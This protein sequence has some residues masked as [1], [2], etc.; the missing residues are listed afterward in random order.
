MILQRL[1]RPPHLVDSVYHYPYCR[2]LPFSQQTRRVETILELETSFQAQQYVLR[3]SK[4]E[5]KQGSERPFSYQNR[6]ICLSRLFPASTPLNSVSTSTATERNEISLIKPSI[7]LQTRNR[8][9]RHGSIPRQQNTSSFQRLPLQIRSKSTNVASGPTLLKEPLSP[10]PSYI[11]P[12]TGILSYLPSSF[13]PYAELIRLDKPT[14][15]YYLFFPCLFSTLLAASLTPITPPS[16]VISTTFLFFAGALV[17]RGAGC[18]IN[19]L[20]DRKLDAHVSRTRFRPLARG[21]LTPFSALAFTSTQLLLGLGVLLQ[22]PLPCLAYGIPSLLLVATYPLFKRI[23]H[24]PQL[25]L[26]LTF[27]WGA[28]MGFP[29]LGI[30]LVTDSTAQAAAACLYASCISWTVLYDFIYA[31]MDLKDDVTAGIKSIAVKHG[32]QTKVILASL[33][34]VQVGLLATAGMVAGFGPVYFVG[35]CGGTALSLGIMVSRVRLASVESCWWWFKNGAWF[36]GLAVSAGL[37]GEYVGRWTGWIEVG[38]K[39][40]G[41]METEEVI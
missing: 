40:R 14:G 6:G 26:G 7:I 21:A 29:A 20:H 32:S 4:A 12:T 2:V 22:L 13:V 19:D 23:T 25:I 27:S 9:I 24:Y 18:A 33:A 35:T 1:S 36:T 8:Q 30:D 15:T 10:L 31:H 38:E 11:A 28:I 16:T 41:K 39:E 34:A 5:P 37:L 3:T 17:M